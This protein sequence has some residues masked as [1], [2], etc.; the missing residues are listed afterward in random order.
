MVLRDQ[1]LIRVISSGRPKNRLSFKVVDHEAF[2]SNLVS[3]LGAYREISLD[4]ELKRFN[5]AL[6]PVGKELWKTSS[7]DSSHY[8]S[9]PNNTK[10]ML[11]NH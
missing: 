9:R 8:R 6:L 7:T 10:R 5:G 1:R 11:E 3:F 4:K 2:K